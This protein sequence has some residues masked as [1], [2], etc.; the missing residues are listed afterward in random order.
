MIGRLSREPLVHFLFIGLLLFLL[1]ASLGSSRT[2]R[3]IRVDEKVMAGLTSQFER[4]WQ[5]PPTADEQG[6]LVESY[7]REEIFYREGIA[8]GLDRDDPT[9][10]RR[11]GQKFAVLA[12]ETQ[13]AA[14]PTDFKLEAW[15]RTHAGRYEEP[16]LISFEQLMVDPAQSGGSTEA[17]LQSARRALAWGADPSKIGTSRMLPARFDFY[18]A[19]LVERDFGP[20]FARQLDHLREGVWEGPV[21]SG[22]GIH[23]VKVQKRVPGRL[24]PL[25]Q[26]R[27]AVARDFEADRR[28]K[29][30]SAY[31]KRLRDEYRVELTASLPR[32]KTNPR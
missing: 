20:N 21:R 24:P 19:D 26:V 16:T 1:N 2:D 11:I 28:A 15:L 30:A 31:Y 8:L 25:D 29:A 32:A 22:Y 10:K 27:K 23:L 17:A 3:D 12:E 9:I 6:A 5:R 4:T 14:S 7:I 13:D 18:P